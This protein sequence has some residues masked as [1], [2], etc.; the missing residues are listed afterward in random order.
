MPVERFS[1]T[2]WI[3]PPRFPL[4]DAHRGVCRATTEPFEPPEQSQRELCNCGYARGRC[5]RFPE[6]SADAVRF[7]ILSENDA[8]LRV[9]YVIERDFAPE[10]HGLLEYSLTEARFMGAVPEPLTSQA[11]AFLASH[12]RRAS[13]PVMRC[14]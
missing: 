13:P 7:S 10:T 9:I 12:F 11:G 4:Q 1:E 14:S 6:E 3:L 2:P 5:D 8:I